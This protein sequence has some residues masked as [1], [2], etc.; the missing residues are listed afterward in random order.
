MQKEFSKRYPDKK[1]SELAKLI[2]EQWL[3][4]NDKEK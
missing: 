4:L 2:A 3:K 1:M